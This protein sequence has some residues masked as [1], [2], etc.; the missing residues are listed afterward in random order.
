MIKFC[1]LHFMIKLVYFGCLLISAPFIGYPAQFD[2][3]LEMNKQHFSYITIGLHTYN[4]YLNVGQC[5]ITGHIENRCL[6]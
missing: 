4:L 1:I 3:Y 5:A 2:F 6:I